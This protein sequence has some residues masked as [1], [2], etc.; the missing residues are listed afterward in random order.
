MMNDIE[1][2]RSHHAHIHV[3]HD[4]VELCFITP[5]SP[6][7]GAPDTKWSDGRHSHQD[8]SD[9]RHAGIP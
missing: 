4:C 5:E 6:G 9:Q 1:V 3:L 8:G 7:L 2:L